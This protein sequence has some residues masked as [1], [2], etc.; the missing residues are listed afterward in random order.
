[1]NIP[2][3][4]AIA[5]TDEL[6]FINRN[7]II[8]HK[9]ACMPSSAKDR[10]TVDFES[11]FFFTKSEKYW[12]EQ[13]IEG[14]RVLVRKG[15]AGGHKQANDPNR[16]TIG[17]V[18]GFS[19]DI[20]TIGRNMRTVWKVNFEPSGESH[21]ASYPTKLI[22]TPIL[23]GCPVGGIVFDPFMGTATTAIVALKLGRKFIGSE[24]NPKYAEIANRRLEPVLAQADLFQ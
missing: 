10:F 3:R 5:M 2:A 9:P 20:T 18:G 19:K 17:I 11:I 4:F 21:Y 16:P 7:H 14:D 8:W 12:F 1:M 15:T 6:Q 23:A 24:L 22:A 13:Q